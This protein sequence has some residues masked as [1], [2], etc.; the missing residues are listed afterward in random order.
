[1]EGKYFKTAT[2]VIVLLLLLRPDT[3]VLALFIDSIGL[4]LLILLLSM[5][6]NAIGAYIGSFC[7]PTIAKLETKLFNNDKFYFRPSLSSIKK[8]PFLLCHAILGFGKLFNIVW[9]IRGQSRCF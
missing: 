1:M 9:L 3:I 5:Q 6:F 2:K 7:I 4:E 8:S